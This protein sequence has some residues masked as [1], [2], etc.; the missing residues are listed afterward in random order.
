MKASVSTTSTFSSWTGSEVS[1][2][3]PAS[4]VQGG[5]FQLVRE[6]ART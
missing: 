1:G 6:R 5:L 3:N 2:D 4:I